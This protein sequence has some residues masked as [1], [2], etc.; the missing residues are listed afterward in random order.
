VWPRPV[1]VVALIN[2]STKPLAVSR[3]TDPGA[4]PD[5]VMYQYELLK[6]LQSP[7]LLQDAVSIPG[8]GELRMF[9]R[10]SKPVEWLRERLRIEVINP[11]IVSIKLKV[12]KH[13]QNEAIEVVDYIATRCVSRTLVKVGKQTRDFLSEL[14]AEERRIRRELSGREQRLAHLASTRPTDDAERRRLEAEAFQL[15]EVLNQLDSEL[16]SAQSAD[17]WSQYLQLVQTAT[18]SNGH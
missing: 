15:K 6:A 16:Q 17:N 12:P 5:T 7:A 3:S 4:A 9:S 10:R 2:A 8:N 13:F 1:E 11:S 14:R 18:A